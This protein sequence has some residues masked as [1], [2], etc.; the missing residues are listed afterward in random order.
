[1]PRVGEAKASSSNTISPHTSFSQRRGGEIRACSS[2]EA[3]EGGLTRHKGR[4]PK[5]PS[6]AVALGLENDLVQAVAARYE[7]QTG[8]EATTRE[9]LGWATEQHLADLIDGLH[10]LGFRGGKIGKRRPR[11]VKQSM[12]DALQSA[13][14]ETGIP[15]S[16]L[17]R[18]CLTWIKES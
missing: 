4:V 18:A 12:W 1:M 6:Q 10:R 17:L 5:V 7:Q 15:A 8:N 11:R 9:V 16:A 2:A 14:N 13:S 3:E